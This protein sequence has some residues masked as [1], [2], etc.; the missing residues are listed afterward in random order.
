MPHLDGDFLEDEASFMGEDQRL[1]LWIIG[2]VI[3]GKQ[4]DPFPV[5]GPESGGRIGDSPA[6]KN[7]DEGYEKF[8]PQFSK[9]SRFEAS[10]G[11]VP[12]SNHQIGSPPGYGL[13][14]G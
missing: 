1:H 12:G 9:E 3:L 4:R 7:P 13:D 14:Q 10:L 8:D 5:H 11:K 2:G 6:C